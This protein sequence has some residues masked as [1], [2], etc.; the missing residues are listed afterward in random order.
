MDLN[1]IKINGTTEYFCKKKG[2]NCVIESSFVTDGA[3]LVA[4]DVSDDNF[5]DLW[6]TESCNLTPLKQ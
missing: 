1:D 3:T 5:L 4:C 2:K 6:A